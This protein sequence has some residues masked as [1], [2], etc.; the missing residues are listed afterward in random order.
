MPEAFSPNGDGLNERFKIIP[1][2]YIEPIEFRI[3]NRWGQLI[4]EDVTGW[5]GMYKGKEQ[6]VGTYTYYVVVKLAN[7]EIKTQSGA[8]S[9]IR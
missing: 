4:S 3:Y 1:T 9:L 7:N 6:P 8:F 5:D 2:G